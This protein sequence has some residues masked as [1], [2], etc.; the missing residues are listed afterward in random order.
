MEPVIRA[1]FMY[2]FLLIM[3]RLSGRRTIGQMTNFDFILLLIISEATQSGLTGENYSI[4]NSVITI[5]ALFLVDI[6]FSLIKNKWPGLEKFI[7]GVPTILIDNGHIQKASIHHSRIDIDDIIDAARNERGL[8][9]LEQIKYA[10][11]EK[12]GK[13]SIIPFDK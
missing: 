11:L 10:I 9:S 7:D 13:I 1:A 8:E 4:T 3:V 2:F 12:N 5:S 6:C